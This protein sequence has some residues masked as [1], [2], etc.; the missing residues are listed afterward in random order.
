M[1][2]AIGVW[3]FRSLFAHPPVRGFGQHGLVEQRPTSNERRIR[4][5]ERLLRAYRSASQSSG[6]T[7]MQVGGADLW[8]EI[9]RR[10]LPELQAILQDGDAAQLAGFLVHFGK[11]VPWGGLSLGVDAYCGTANSEELASL[12]FDKLICLAEAVGALPYE[13]PEQGAWAEN[14]YRP[15]DEVV[16]LIER[17]IGV[18]IAPPGGVVYTAGLPSAQGVF[19]YRHMNS[20]YVAWRTAALAG[21]GANVCEYGGGLG[22]VALYAR[23]MGIAGYTIFD[24]PIANVFAGNYLLNALGED[25]VS[26]YGEA[27]NAAAIK[28]LPFWACLDAADRSFAVSVN[29]DSFPEIDQKLVRQYLAEIARTT[30]TYFL[31]VNQEAQA[32]MH[33]IGSQLHL[34]TLLKGDPRFQRVQRSR[35]W[36]RE[37][38]VEELYLLGASRAR[39][40]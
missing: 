22:L 15:I 5:A 33:A 9:V 27:E 14:A 37:G 17:E 26:L 2:D 19:H 38:Y 25:A 31:S 21:A 23:R 40:P 12:Y 6:Q 11:S 7:R 39:L 8:T 18:S 29:Q 34:P 30:T 13:N 35:Y 24:L 20:I 36:I 16:Q 28:V 10:S 1:Q 3:K 32:P 4:I